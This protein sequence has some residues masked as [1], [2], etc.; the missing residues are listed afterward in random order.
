MAKTIIAALIIILGLGA[1]IGLSSL[2]MTSPWFPIGTAV[3]FAAITGS[4]LADKWEWLTGSR[5]FILNYICHLAVVSIL[6]AAAFYVVNYAFAD[7]ESSHTVK[8]VVER[9]YSETRYKTRRIRRN[10]YGN[11]EPYKVY[12]M[13]LRFDNGMKK[14]RL[15]PLSK[16]NRV[17]K[18]DTINVN[19]AQGA[20]HIP[21][22]K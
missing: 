13:E 14:S 6:M 15:I 3:A 9:R 11:G 7:A 12:Y 22:I 19:I 2:T 5:R 18:G 1:I 20:F 10:V 17:R 4:V 21:V 8:A 16:F